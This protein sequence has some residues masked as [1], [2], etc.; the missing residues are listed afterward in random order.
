MGEAHLNG[1]TPNMVD[2][3]DAVYS[4]TP[5]VLSTMGL[6][7]VLV[8]ILTVSLAFGISAVILISWTIVVVFSIGI[9]VYQDGVLGTVA[10]Q[11]ADTGGLAWIAP[12]L[13]FTVILG[14]G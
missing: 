8:C 13:T 14:L 7:L 1:F 9:L 12:P 5:V 10:P 6:C 3:I 11:V 2:S 4:T